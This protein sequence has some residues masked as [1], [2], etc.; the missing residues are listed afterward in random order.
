MAATS[1]FFNP[2]VIEQAGVSFGEIAMLADAVHRLIAGVITKMDD[3][4]E[5]AETPAVAARELAKQIGLLADLGAR[6]LGAV[7]LRGATAQE[8]L[9]S[10]IW[11]VIAKPA[12]G[13]A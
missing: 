7:E 8:W 3:P 12:Q 6:S 1:K 9:H 13:G 5:D 11:H 10:P 2:V 4:A